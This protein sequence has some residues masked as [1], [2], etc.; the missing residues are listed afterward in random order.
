MDVS[1]FRLQLERQAKLIEK[2]QA[3]KADRNLASALEGIV[4]EVDERV[5]DNGPR[6]ASSVGPSARGVSFCG[7]IAV[8]II[9]ALVIIVVGLVVLVMELVQHQSMMY[10]LIEMMRRERERL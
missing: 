4:N 2:F 10:E 5:D 6:V 8:A 1:K 7:A 9:A 3:E